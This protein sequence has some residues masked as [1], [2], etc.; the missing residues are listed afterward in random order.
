ML[1]GLI[2]RD[3]GSIRLFGRDPAADPI[4]AL[5]GV[6][7]FIEEPRLYPYLSGR[8][9]LELLAA[10]DRGR[11]GRSQIDEVLDL[12]ELRDRADDRAGESR[13]LCPPRRDPRREGARPLHLRRRRAACVRGHR[14]RRRHARLRIPSAREHQRPAHLGRARARAHA[15]L[16]RDRCLRR[17][18]DRDRQLR[19]AALGR[20]PAERRRRRRHDLLRARPR[21]SW[22]RCRRSR[23]RART[24]SSPSCTRGTAP[25]RHNELGADRARDLDLDPLRCASSGRRVDCLP[26]PRRHELRQPSYLRRSS[27]R[28][29]P[30][31]SLLDSL[32][33]RRIVYAKIIYAKT[34]EVTDVGDRAQR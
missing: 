20:H 4:A 25:S 7:G 18:D 30:G 12:V 13:P 10:L 11:A 33:R 26:P 24:S 32:G 2:R 8:A 27:A 14:G 34:K 3:A 29:P 28:A 21:R 31:G 17:A 6:A 23:A 22:P 9:N 15:H 19:P 5:A 16:R 1:L